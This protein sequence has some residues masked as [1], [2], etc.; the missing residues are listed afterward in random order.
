MRAGAAGLTVSVGACS[1]PLWHAR[2]T[3]FTTAKTSSMLRQ[4]RR[5]AL[6]GWR[7]IVPSMTTSEAENYETIY[8]LAA[9]KLTED[10]LT[11]W[12]REH[13]KRGG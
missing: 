6:M 8:N 10:E 5:H 3:A 2:K 9:G 1:I 11:A 12:F 4:W 13:M 7:T